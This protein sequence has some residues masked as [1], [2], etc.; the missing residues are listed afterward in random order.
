RAHRTRDILKVMND[1]INRTLSRTILTSGTTIL[2]VL[3]L[4]LLGGQSLLGLSLILFVG[5]ITGTYSS[6]YIACPFVHWWISR[7]GAKAE[8]EHNPLVVSQTSSL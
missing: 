2:A 1:S 3:A 8:L 5:I 6:I 7:K 4:L